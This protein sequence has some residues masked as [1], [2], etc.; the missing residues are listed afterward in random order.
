MCL[1][2]NF[3]LAVIWPDKTYQHKPRGAYSDQL[4]LVP[5]IPRCASFRLPWGPPSPPSEDSDR[6]QKGLS[7]SG[8]QLHPAPTHNVMLYNN[9][10]IDSQA[11]KWGSEYFWKGFHIPE[12]LRSVARQHVQ[13]FLFASFVLL[14][15]IWQP[16]SSYLSTSGIQPR[17]TVCKRSS[18]FLLLQAT[19]YGKA[20]W[21]DLWC[22]N[23]ARRYGLWSF[24]AHFCSYNVPRQDISA[25]GGGVRNYSGCTK[26]PIEMCLL[27]TVY[28]SYCV[29]VCLNVEDYCA[30]LWWELCPLMTM[31]IFKRVLLATLFLSSSWESVFPGDLKAAGVFGLCLTSNRWRCGS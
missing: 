8:L 18:T 9:P 1:I 7:A 20:S 23:W 13:P 2:S 22:W 30:L 15:L 14:S 21:S 31:S 19:A 10:L 24:C 17:K 16:W 27:H 28:V 6:V 12:P 5:L 3:V 26:H 11:H 4:A 29:Y 25:R